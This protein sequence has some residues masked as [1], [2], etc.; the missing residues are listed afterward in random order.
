METV[1]VKS[2][3]R[4]A[5]INELIVKDEIQYNKEIFYKSIHT[6][7][8]EGP[9]SLNC[10]FGFVELMVQADHKMIYIIDASINSKNSIKFK[11]KLKKATLSDLKTNDHQYKTNSCYYILKDMKFL[12]GPFY[13]NDFTNFTELNKNLINQKVYVLNKQQDFKILTSVKN[14]N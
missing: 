6:N 10:G 11:L 14:D 5:Q 1:N 4:V 7:K 9:Y 12:Q 13:I 3:L 8:F 2:F